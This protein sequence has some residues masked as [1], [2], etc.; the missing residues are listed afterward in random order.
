MGS[1]LVLEKLLTVKNIFCY[2]LDG[3]SLNG[4]QR[5]LGS[6][7]LVLNDAG[8]AIATTSSSNASSLSNSPMHKMDIDEMVDSLRESEKVTAPKVRASNS[9]CNRPRVEEG[10]HSTKGNSNGRL[11]GC[12]RTF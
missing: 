9:G 11:I 6:I 2:C 8:N 3:N 12:L 4:G 10:T 7:V 1:T 5:E